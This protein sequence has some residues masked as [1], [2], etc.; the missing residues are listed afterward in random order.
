MIGVHAHR[1]MF[2]VCGIMSMVLQWHHDIYSESVEQMAVTA[3]KLLTE[4]L[5]SL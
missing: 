4:P 5:V 1:N 3:L 2:I